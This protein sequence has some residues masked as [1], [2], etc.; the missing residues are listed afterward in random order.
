MQLLKK[1]PF[2]LLLLV[3]FF[4]LHGGVENYG[5]LN[6]GE[7][8]MVAGVILL[9]M[10]IL[11]LI[12]LYFT[13]N[14]IYASLIIFFI[15]LW[16]LFFGSLH[17]W[18]KATSFLSFIKSYT[19]L[20]PL[21]IIATIIWIIF[22]R[23]NKPLHPKLVFY[24]NLLLLLYCLYDGYLFFGKYK[25]GITIA[26]TTIPFDKSKVV[27][28][29]NV[30]FLLFDEYAGYKSLKDSFAFA[31]DSL[32]DYLQSNSFNVLPTH[33]NY[34][35]TPFS[36]SSMLNMQYVDSNYNHQ[37]LT[38]A[39]VQHR[40]GE[41]R[42]AQVFDIFRSM[43]YSIENYSIFDVKDHPALSGSNP[44]FP[45]HHYLLTNKIFHNRLIK[46]IGWWLATG[47]FEISFIKNHYL[48]KDDK[49]NKKAEEMIIKSTSEKTD[50]PKFCYGHFFLPHGPFYRD[51]TG[52]L[53][54]PGQM[55]LLEDKALY[56]SYL[57][58]TNTV[59]KSLVKNIVAN[60][61]NAIAIVMSDHGFYNYLSK[62]DNDPLNYDNFCLVRFPD[63]NYLPTKEKWSNV[64]F[65]RY[66]FNCEFGQSMPYLKDSTIWVNE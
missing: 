19:I 59:I 28:K 64:N 22:L 56:L 17:D 66:L 48:Y 14:Y 9:C 34:D 3:V 2:F 42:N 47:R 58:Y 25:K 63:K 36:M 11:F 54:Q 49:F 16:Y 44:L 52:K 18:I 33:S 15:S 21:L 39:D 57:K 31:N 32:Y 40:F 43:G 10:L 27:K 7:V 61:P 51:S 29:P 1:I 26:T 6:L 60:D 35:F 55:M 53:N 23:R 8:V 41:I 65:F 12:T 50:K 46:D 38:Q 5:Y 20:V 37:L 4:C 45:I 30:Y 13:R 62:D 24:L